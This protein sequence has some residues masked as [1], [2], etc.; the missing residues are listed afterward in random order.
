MNGKELADYLKQSA[1]TEIAALGIIIDNKRTE[2][3]ANAGNPDNEESAVYWQ[4]HKFTAEIS[5][6]WDFYVKDPKTGEQLASMILEWTG[7]SKQEVIRKANE[8]LTN[9]NN[10][11]ESHGNSQS[12]I[13]NYIDEGINAIISCVTNEWHTGGNWEVSFYYKEPDS[14]LPENETHAPHTFIFDKRINLLTDEEMNT[15]GFTK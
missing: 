2:I 3:I 12:F 11:T 5:T 4:Q 10:Y 7:S 15:L 9:S 1:N 6:D 14:V 8:F 13:D